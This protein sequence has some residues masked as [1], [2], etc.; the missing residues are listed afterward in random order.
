[1]TSLAALAVARGGVAHVARSPGPAVRRC[2]ATPAADDSCGFYFQPIGS[3]GWSSQQ[4]APPGTTFFNPSVAKSGN[5]TVIAAA[6]TDGLDFYRQPIGGSGWNHQLVSG[7]GTVSE[8]PSVAQS[9]NSTVI[10]AMNPNLGLDF[11]WQ[12]IGGSGWNHQ[13]V[14]ASLTTGSPPSIAQVGNSTVIA[15][16]GG[17]ESL[18]FYWQPIGGSGWNHQ[19]VAPAGTS[20]SAPTIARVGNSTVIAT[21]GANGSLQFYWQPIGGSGLE[22]PA[23]RARGHQHLGSVDRPGRELHGDHLAGPE[24]QRGLLR[25]AHWRLR[26]ES[27]AGGAPGPSFNISSIAQ[28][29]SSSVIVADGPNVGQR[30]Y[31]QPIGSSGWHCQIVPSGS[32]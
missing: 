9:G 24:Q 30:F 7:P 13:Q 15:A 3:A 11:Y 16:L 5:S 14:A 22:S 4:V 23:G 19:Q 17:N 31:Y 21:Q 20:F 10:A 1:M 27:P 28:V 29:G 26:L 8:Y 12:P 25:A 6:G 32:C 18:D 2:I